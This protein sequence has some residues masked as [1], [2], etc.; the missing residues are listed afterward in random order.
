MSALTVKARTALAL[1]VP[2]LWRA[3]RYRVGLKLGVHSVLR[4]QASI[5]EGSFFSDALPIKASQLTASRQWSKNHCYFGWYRVSD[6]S[7]PNWH[8][9]PFARGAVKQPARPWW[10]I[11]DFDETLG[12]IK[13]VWEASRFDWV[14][15]FAQRALNGEP[16]GLA[17]LNA[18]LADWVKFNPPYRGPNWK[19]GQ[20]AS[21]RVMHL[22]M[23]AALLTQHRQSA[24]PLQALVRAHLRRIVPTI[25]YAVAQDNNHGTSEAAA[26]FIGGS[27]LFVLG[28][29]EGDNSLQLGRKW[30][31]NRA[32]R[33]IEEDGSFSQS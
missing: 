21:I 18:W 24:R 6:N 11:P 28:D 14:L 8:E 3:A 2:N 22:A 27:W 29:S 26:L 30:L 33:L 7:V 32:A 1:G 9:N 20:E 10:L 15:T 12:D 13:A 5:P 31:E 4:I 19:C 23:A 16:A 17:R 25:H